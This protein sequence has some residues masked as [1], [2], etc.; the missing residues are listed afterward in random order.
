[1]KMIENLYIMKTNGVL[2]YS[3]NPDAEIDIDIITGFSASVANFGREALKTVIENI[4]L[5]ENRKL[6]LYPVY[7]ENL[8]I[9]A[10]G[11]END[12]ESLTNS[13]LHSIADEIIASYAPKYENIDNNAVETMIEEKLY[14]KSINRRN[15]IIRYAIAAVLIAPLAFLLAKLSALIS[16]ALAVVLGIAGEITEFSSLAGVFLIA[17]ILVILLYVGPSLIFGFLTVHR[18]VSIAIMVVYMAFTVILFNPSFRYILLAYS[19]VS[20]IVGVT[21][22]FLGVR[23]AQKRWLV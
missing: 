10:I 18:W 1:M 15:R 11:H 20:I 6:F 23:L 17:T 7:D 3:Y 13:I 4:E 2:L 14:T 5:G 9:S 22:V 16:E 19:P 21:F 8:L 12:N